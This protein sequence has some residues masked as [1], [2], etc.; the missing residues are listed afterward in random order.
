MRYEIS[1]PPFRSHQK[2]ALGEGRAGEAA[3]D[4]C[5]RRDENRRGLL[6]WPLLEIEVQSG[7][8]MSL[9][10]TGQSPRGGGKA[11]CVSHLRKRVLFLAGK[12]EMS[13]S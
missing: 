3:S 8:K 6:V 5:P 9:S 1:P 11:W 7:G 4:S 12:S 10:L 13:Q 2:N